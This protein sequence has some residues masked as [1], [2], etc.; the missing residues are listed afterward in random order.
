MTQIIMELPDIYKQELETVA[1]SQQKTI[2]ELVS[3]LIQ[4]FIESEQSGFDVT[5]DPVYQMGDTDSEEESADSF[6]AN[7]DN[8]HFEQMG[9]AFPK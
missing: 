8:H 2:Q 9:G 4:A 6:S 7:T 5:K 3:E 1:K